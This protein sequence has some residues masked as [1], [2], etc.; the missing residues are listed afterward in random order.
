M[1]IPLL[2]DKL[3]KTASAFRTQTIFENTDF[4]TGPNHLTTIWQL[5]EPLTRETQQILA[6]EDYGNT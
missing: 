6:F 5:P 2:N 1:W 3:P 4:G